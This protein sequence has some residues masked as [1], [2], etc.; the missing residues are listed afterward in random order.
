MSAP[1]PDEPSRFLDP[2]QLAQL[3]GLELRARRIVEG[4]LSGLHR[5]RRRG[6]SVEFAEHR[7]YTPG[8]DL[9][10]LDWKVFG[11]RDRYYL[12][13]FEEETNLVCSL[14][15]D[16]SESMAYR[17]AS[18][19]L[20][21]WDYAACLAAALAWVVLHQQDAVG[22][23]LVDETIRRALPPSGR[24]DQFREVVRMLEEHRPG[25][26][27]R[28]GQVL[29][30]Q[31]ARLPHRGVV[32]LI[33]DLFDDVATLLQGLRRLRFH[34]HDVGVL[35]VVDP[36]EQ[37]FPFE[38]ATEFDGLEGSGSESVAPRAIRSAYRAE[39]TR[40]LREIEGGCREL[41]AVYLLA[42][43]DRPPEKTLLKFLSRRGAK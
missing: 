17:S 16:A 29:H 39:F 32:L 10:Y 6:F 22:L 12:K 24:A 18:A 34:G 20:G 40:F 7:E 41:G 36:A 37:E 3:S 15:V 42:R 2:R 19:A 5:S 33:S 8:D 13:Q 25:G 38:E 9:R 43:T 1:R 27:S 28:L 14:V 11:K 30:E 31:A 21:K 23:S 35:H 26:T 4:R